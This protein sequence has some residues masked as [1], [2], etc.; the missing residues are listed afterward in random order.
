MVVKWYSGLTGD[1]TQ[2]KVAATCLLCCHIPFCGCQQNTGSPDPQEYCGLYP[3]RPVVSPVFNPEGASGARE[4]LPLSTP[5]PAKVTQLLDNA[6]PVA[7][8]LEA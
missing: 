1:D 6:R 2:V 7:G 8:L 4:S 5:T 3:K